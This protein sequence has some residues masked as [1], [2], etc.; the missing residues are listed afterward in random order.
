M[1]GNDNMLDRVAAHKLKKYSAA[2]GGMASLFSF[3]RG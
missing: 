2:A 1:R 3:L